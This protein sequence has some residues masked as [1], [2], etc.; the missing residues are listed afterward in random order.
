[1][2]R[3]L[4]A[5]SPAAFARDLERRIVGCTACP[6]LVEHCRHIAE[7]KR[8]AYRDE[9]YWGRP[10]PTFGD[11]DPQLLVVGLAPGAHG[12]NRTGRVF[13]GDS[14]GDWLYRALHVTGFANQARSIGLDDGL[15]L[16]GAAVTCAG[17]CAP[18]QNKPAR[19]ELE[20]CRPF[21]I[22]ELQAYRGLRVVLALGGIALDAVLKSWSAADFPEFSSK[23]K[24]GHGAVF[25]LDGAPTLVTCYHPSRQNTQTGRLT[26][27][28]FHAVFRR[29][30]R[31]VDEGRERE[32]P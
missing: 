32:R 6:R 14:S 27:R 15:E 30:R 1:M 17:R 21:L 8:R 5:P 22:E 26:R 2:A 29:C 24:F 23:P 12:A 18:P 25:P 31:L 7:V 16:R 4:Q 9:N 19:D 10:V 20:R 11:P 28:Q 13:T 3:R